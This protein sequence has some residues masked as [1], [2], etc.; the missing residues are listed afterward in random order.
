MSIV[1]FDGPPSWFLDASGTGEST[2][3]PWVE[4]VGLIASRREKIRETKHLPSVSC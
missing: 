1:V 2:K 3:Y 4:T